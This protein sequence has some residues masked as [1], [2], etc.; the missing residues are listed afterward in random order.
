MWRQRFEYLL[1]L[2][3]KYSLKYCDVTAGVEA[4]GKKIILCLILKDFAEEDILKR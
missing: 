1:F 4:N 2:E 3:L